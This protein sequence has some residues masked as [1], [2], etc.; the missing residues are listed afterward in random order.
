MSV[1]P[2]PDHSWLGYGFVN[3]LRAA[4]ALVAQLL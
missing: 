4:A 2:C 1:T 3:I